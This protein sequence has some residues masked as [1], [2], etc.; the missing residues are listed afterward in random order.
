[1]LT[2]PGAAPDGILQ[3][4]YT[5]PDVEAAL[6]T[7]AERFRI[8]PWFVRGPIVSTKARYHG[9]PTDLSLTIAIAY[10]GPL[11][12]ELIQQNNDV[13][14]VYQEVI[15]ARGH[16]FHHWAI[17]STR[18][19]AQVAEYT[20]VGKNAV[21]TTE[22]PSGARVAYFDTRA[23]LPGFIEVIEMTEANAARYAKMQAECAAWDG[24]DPIRRV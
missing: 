18:Y 12:L 11:M 1:M 17:G 23:E 5:V 20:R 8:G 15:A 21:Y 16:G 19:D 10:S 24:R 2:N 7:Y 3:I 14:S 9:K 13:P 22:T 4:A 6:R